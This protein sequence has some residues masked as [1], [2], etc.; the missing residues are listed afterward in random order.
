MKTKRATALGCVFLLGLIGFVNCDKWQGIIEPTDSNLEAKNATAFAEN[1][2]R[3]IHQTWAF[4]EAHWEAYQKVN[5]KKGGEVEIQSGF[6]LLVEAGSMIP[7]RNTTIFGEV[8]G[9]SPCSEWP[10]GCIRIHFEPSGLRFDPPAKLELRFDK[11]AVDIGDVIY[12]NWWNPGTSQ[13]ITI[14]DWNETGGNY[15]WDKKGMKV[16]FNI[17]HFS[18]YSFSK[19]Y[20]RR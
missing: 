19:D 9:I 14:S 17:H 16:R 11:L 20:K 12:L 1:S 15:Q 8:D 3:P 6:T 13:W 2:E 5:W 18:I 10:T 4:T 7:A